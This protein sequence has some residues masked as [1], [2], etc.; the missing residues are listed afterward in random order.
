MRGAV[1]LALALA[2]PRDGA[3]FPARGLIV[4]LTFCVILAT[5]VGQGLTLAPLL[6]RLGMAGDRRDR[7]EE[8]EARSATARAGLARVEQLLDQPWAPPREAGEHLVGHYQ[9]RLRTLTRAP[10]T[11][12]RRPATSRSTPPPRAGSSGSGSRAWTRSGASSSGSG[13]R[14]RS[15][16]TCSAGSSG[17]STSRSSGREA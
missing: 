13:T 8:L 17:T 5:L 4:Y 6:R 12:R 14:A 15:T 9:D 11:A 16:T 7:R 3:T 10:W 2:L 1:S